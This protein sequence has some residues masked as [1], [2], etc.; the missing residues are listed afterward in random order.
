MI[1][2]FKCET[3]LFSFTSKGFKKKICEK[4]NNNDL[5]GRVYHLII[6]FR[7]IIFLILLKFMECNGI[8]K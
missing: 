2:F 7:N 4:N 3:I 5:K 8:D 6:I 1:I